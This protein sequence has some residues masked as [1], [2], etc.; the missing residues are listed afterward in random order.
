[1]KTPAFRYH[2]AEGLEDALDALA[3]HGSD[4]Q[5]LAGG[6][7]LMPLMAFRLSAPALLVDIN[8]IAG[9]DGVSVDSGRVRIGALVRHA[10]LAA[11][12]TIAERQPIFA[13]AVEH[14]AH[15]AV[16]NRGT[17][18]GSIA[19]ADPA[20]E[21]PACCVALGAEIV[22]RSAER[23]RRSVPSER[24]YRGMFET[25]CA[26]DEMVTE[27]V[28]P[29]LDGSERWGFAEFS[30]R[31]GDF[32]LS[33]VAFRA[34][35]DAEKAVVEDL[36]LVVFG[37]EPFPHLSEGAARTARGE[38]LN[39]A[40]VEAVA[41]AVAAEIQPI[42]SLGAGGPLKRQ[43]ARTLCRRALSAVAEAAA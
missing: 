41:A 37:S 32:A 11:S 3:Q 1:M 7:S 2:A 38:P 15:P 22:L 9:L 20:A 36:R 17:F 23:G 18:G 27:V 5:L 4:A 35:L 28:V 14:V 31:H 25:D 26:P 40:T 39:A 43:L 19:L 21:F 13:R 6:Q 33:G 8:R 34:R 42:P 16:R 30:R 10:Q 29:D 12:A 24:F